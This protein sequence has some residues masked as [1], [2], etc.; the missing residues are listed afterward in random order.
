MHHSGV[1]SWTPVM[2]VAV[3]AS[4]KRC[5]ELLEGFLQFGALSGTMRAALFE[6]GLDRPRV[7]AGVLEVHGALDAVADLRAVRSSSSSLRTAWSKLRAD[8]RPARRIH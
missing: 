4:A 7:G 3:G 6:P 1:R 2:G 5:G 8:D